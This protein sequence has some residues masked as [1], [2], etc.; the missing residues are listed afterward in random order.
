MN[1]NAR[2]YQ[3][4]LCGVAL[5]ICQ[6][7]AAYRNE[8]DQIARDL[9][10]KALTSNTRTIAVVDL[11]DLNG[12]VTE[13]GRF[14][15]EEL[16]SALAEEGSLQVID[17]IHLRSILQEH[18]LAATGL[19]D[20]LTARK[21]GEITGVQGLVTGTI[22]EFGDSVR[23]SAKV[24]DTATA[25]I[26][27]AVRGDIPKTDAIKELLGQD[28]DAAGTPGREPSAPVPSASPVIESK[29]TQE[30]REFSFQLQRC[31]VDGKDSIVCYL[32]ITNNNRQDRDLAIGYTCD[33]VLYDNLG[34]E[35]FPSRWEI[36]A[37]SSS[38]KSLNKSLL[39]GVPVPASVRFKLAST[40]GYQD[41]F[42]SVDSI[43]AMK[44]SIKDSLFCYAATF[45]G[46]P[47]RT[48]R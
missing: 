42:R 12:S 21:L 39:S 32:V 26:H 45:H 24:L 23:I 15:A 27:A 1:E 35:Y 30:I 48:G 18:K 3:L 40:A 17:R 37:S 25:R 47:L 34:R 8:I 20:P 46:I 31:E 36:G 33:Y 11:T 2:S 5:L 19:I 14:V 41:D 43:S 16:S 44:I 38:N 7:A 29:Q 22:T 10:D 4:A 13:L 28:I 6:S 9:A